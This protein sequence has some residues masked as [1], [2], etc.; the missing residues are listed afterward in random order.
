M[1]RLVVTKALDYQEHVSEYG[2]HWNFFVTLFCIRLMVV[3]M[4]CL[5]PM[6]LRLCLALLAVCVYQWFLVNRGLSDFVAHAPRDTIFAMNREGVLGIVG[7]VAI[8]Y[9][10]EE[11]GFQVWTHRHRTEKVNRR[12]Q[13]VNCTKY[14]VCCSLRMQR[15]CKKR[16]TEM[17]TGTHHLFCLCGGVLGVQELK[18][19]LPSMSCVA[20]VASV[21]TLL[22][23]LTMLSNGFIQQTSRQG[24][25]HRLESCLG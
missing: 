14:Q 13:L 19:G 15:R 3:P 2:V 18:G 8:Y 22:W 25:W 5:R 6:R 12:R 20:V 4:S 21:N 24:P 7:F 16:S 23:G 17:S 1:S 11:L 9:I 10:G